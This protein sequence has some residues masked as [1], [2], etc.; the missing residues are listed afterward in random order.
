MTPPPAPPSDSDA[1]RAGG[2]RLISR[3]LP[4][5]IRLWLQSQLD[6]IEGLEFAIDGKDRQILAGYLPGVNLAARQAV[7]QGLHVST[8]QVNAVDI[9]VNLPQVLRGKPLRLLQP[10]PV[11]GQVTMLAADL[12]ASL[13]SPL[14]GQGLQ[15]VLKQ[16]VAAAAEPLPLEQWLGQ[17]EAVPQVE[18][19]LGTER[20][21][22]RWA[23]VSPGADSLELTTGLVMKA[24]RW[25]CLQQPA[26]VLVPTTGTAAA[27]IALEEIAFDL[28]PEVDIRTLAVTPIG[29]EL[30]GTVRVIPA[31]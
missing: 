7:Y 9:R 27:P 6:H 18:S 29:I 12:S 25:L 3:L 1:P 17:G 5:A 10:F 28:G 4:P 8:A 20:L 24:G 11:S 31:D 21:T 16:L 22:L 30:V 15:D 13:R 26:A 19:V 14:L 23:N 2:S